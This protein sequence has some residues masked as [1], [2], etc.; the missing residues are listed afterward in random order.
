MEKIRI[1]G[2]SQLQRSLNKERLNVVVYLGDD[3]KS[4]SLL[5]HI[6]TILAIDELD[7]VAFI[8]IDRH[9]LP[10]Q[11]YQRRGISVTPTVCYYIGEQE[12]G[13]MTG[14]HTLDMLINNIA[15]Y[16]EKMAKAA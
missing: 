13:R 7:E 16:Q 10:E 3:N 2:E 9:R 15:R 11:Y 8:L 1:Y 6:N 14:M 5:N 4:M 12:K